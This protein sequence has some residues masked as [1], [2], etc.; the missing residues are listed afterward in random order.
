MIEIAVVILNWNGQQLLEQFLP[1]V[2]KHSPSASIFIIDNA[3][4]D[5]SLV[6]LKNNYSE[7]SVIP[8]SKNLG[9]AGGYNEGLKSI[10]ATYYCLLNSD[11][12]VTPNWLD[13]IITHFNTHPNTGIIQPHILDFNRQENFEY[14]GAA[15][16]FI[17]RMGFPYCR[18]RIIHTIEK[19]VGQYDQD[20]KV[21]W[22]SGACFFIR[23]SVFDS[24]NGFDADFFAHQEEID[25]CWRAHHLGFSTFSLGRSKVYHIGAASLPI[26]STKIYLNHRNSLYMLVKNLPKRSLYVILFQRLSWDGLIA[27][28]YLLQGKPN[29]FF[30][31]IKAHLHFYKNFK[32]MR[33]KRGQLLNTTPYFTLNNLL[34]SYYLFNFK[35][36]SSFERS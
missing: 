7:I 11:V 35:K 24:L 1:A 10:D 21:F 27:L 25:L 15:G 5:N 6:F 36:I 13:P 34:I 8:L 30:A 28:M 26:S 3:S 2:V 23:K 31:V 29:F 14:A 16:G 9:F 20:Q 19:D 18:G 33:K 4:T 32:R 12:L 22:A 17:D